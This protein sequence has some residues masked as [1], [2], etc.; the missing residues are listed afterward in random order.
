ME[1]LDGAALGQVVLDLT[2]GWHRDLRGLVALGEPAETFYLAIRTSVP[3]EHWETTN[4]TLLGD[5][6]HSMSPAGGSGANTALLDAGLLCADLV[7]ASLGRRPLLKAIR[8]YEERM[9]GYGFE[10]V[11]ASQ[12]ASARY[13]G[14]R[15][16]RLLRWLAQRR[17]SPAAGE[18]SAT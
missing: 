4:V 12:Q 13:A 8:D 5:A 14:H 15:Q 18:A 16:G 17:T 6:I 1:A 2:R 3:I 9:V 7:A 10:A 11:R